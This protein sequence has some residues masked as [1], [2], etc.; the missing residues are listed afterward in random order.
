MNTPTRQAPH[1]CDQV[2]PKI[3]PSCVPLTRSSSATMIQDARI[4]V[5]PTNGV[6]LKTADDRRARR[7]RG[8]GVD[9]HRC[10]QM[11]PGSLRPW[12]GPGDD[13]DDQH[14]D[15]QPALEHLAGRQA[16]AFGRRFLRRRHRH[17]AIAE[18]LRRPPDLEQE[19]E[20][21]EADDGADDVGQI[22]PEIDRGRQLAGDVAERADHGERPA[23][24]HAFL[25]AD[26]IE[27]D[28][29][30]Q[31]REDGDDL[32][33]RAGQRQR[34]ACRSPRPSAMIGAPSAP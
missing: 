8:R 29:R 33:D 15:R 25:A 1:I 21:G 18:R 14:D 6:Q 5:P 27:Q 12:P 3:S 16:V 19:Q 10:S 30:R 13:H 28:P 22:R 32:A 9:L 24:H 11:M 26:E 23:V 2:L 34:A 17:A 7:D 31:Q 4:A 20:A